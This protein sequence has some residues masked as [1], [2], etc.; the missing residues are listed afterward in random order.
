[1]LFNICVFFCFFSSRRLPTRCALVTGVH[2]CALPISVDIDGHQRQRVFFYVV[3]KLNY[4]IILGKPWMEEE[5]VHIS[6]KKGCLT[7]GS[8]GVRVWNRAKQPV[9][10]DR[11]SDV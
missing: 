9:P 3:P 6:A 2:T 1:M 10:G 11:K 4:S 7:M 5:D 8:S